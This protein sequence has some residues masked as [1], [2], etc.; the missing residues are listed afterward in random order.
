[1]KTT[2]EI[3][4]SVDVN[5][6]GFQQLAA[7]VRRQDVTSRESKEAKESH[8]LAMVT[9][10]ERLGEVLGAAFLNQYG[11]VGENAFLTWSAGLADLSREQIKKG[12]ANFMRSQDRFIDLKRFRALCLDLSH[13]GLVELERAYEEACTKPSPKERQQW[14]H[15][16]VYHAGRLTGWWELHAMPRDQMLPRFKYNYDMLCKRVADGED[17]N[18][19]V[20]Q[21]IPR[22]IPQP[23]SGEENARRMQSLKEQMGWA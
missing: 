8:N 21:A 16:A 10:W 23:L 15:A 17:I 9:L 4:K 18:L 19:D 1:M 7:T 14:S 3:L 12:F 11:L 22:V 2:E 13:L 6:K 20:P 5:L